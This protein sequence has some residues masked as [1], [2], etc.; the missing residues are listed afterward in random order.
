MAFDYAETAADVDELLA[1]FG[2]SVTL[3]TRTGGTYNTAT[4]TNT[5]TT[6][7]QTVTGVVLEWNQ[8]NIDGSLV[9]VGDKRLLLSP[10]TTAGAALTAPAAND[11]VTI[12]SAV[13]TIVRVVPLN[14]AG[15]VVMY[16]CNIRG[17]R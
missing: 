16:E 1:E 10:V 2:Q 17:A 3:T 11:T 15:T 13:Y 4:G 8:R 9:L 7:T 12:G 14:P 5:P 6:A